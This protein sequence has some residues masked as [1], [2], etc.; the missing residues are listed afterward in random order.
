ME[1]TLSA[2]QSECKFSILCGLNRHDSTCSFFF[3]SRRLTEKSL[4]MNRDK[5]CKV[6][7]QQEYVLPFRLSS[8]LI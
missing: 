5:S 2:A 6:V 7:V 4:Y 8:W 3:S 1:T